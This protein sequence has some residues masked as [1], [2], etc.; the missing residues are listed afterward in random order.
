MWTIYDHPIDFPDAFVVREWAVQLGSNM[1]GRRVFTADTLEGARLLIP[2]HL[3]RQ[4][5]APDDDPVIV[6]T[7]F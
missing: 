1:E 4:P 6:E 3:Y 2:P 7:W 5:R